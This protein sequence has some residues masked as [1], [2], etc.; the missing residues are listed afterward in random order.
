MKSRRNAETIAGSVSASLGSRIGSTRPAIIEWVAIETLRSNPKNARTHSKKQIRTIA[1]SL[2]SFGFISPIIVDENYVALAGNGRLQ[3][4]RLEGITHVPVIRIDH[5]STA[6]K[7]AY[8]IADNRIAELAGWDHEI[9]AVEF[10]ELA[11]LLPVEGLDIS[12]TG[13][14]K[15]CCATIPGTKVT[16]GDCALALQAAPE[17]GKNHG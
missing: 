12:L 1:A 11:E 10:G 7:R 15:R 4:A 16:S 14:S 6:Q 17:W 5:L 3:A 2:R 13:F 8:L 9:L